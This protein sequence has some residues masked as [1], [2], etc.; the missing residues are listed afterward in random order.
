MAEAAVSDMEDTR[1]KV[2]AFQTILT[3]LLE[4]RRDG[5]G[6]STAPE[7]GDKRTKR[8][9]GSTERILK[10]AGEGF[11]QQQRS[12]AEIQQGL[13]DR[14]WHYPQPFLGTPLRRLVQRRALRRTMVT[15]GGKKLWKY[16]LY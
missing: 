5:V 6:A 9:G 1:L 14:G 7:L 4:R 16:S 8:T 13:A 3:K 2:A 12:L 15:Q 11:F 10:L